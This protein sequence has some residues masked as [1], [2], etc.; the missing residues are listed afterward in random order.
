M[1]EG[2]NL[3]QEVSELPDAEDQETS[4][5]LLKELLVSSVELEITQ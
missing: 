3:S 2:L 5:L 4:S 1:T